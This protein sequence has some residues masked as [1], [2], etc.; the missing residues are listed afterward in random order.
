MVQ[1]VHE[2]TKLL[3]KTKWIRH[4]LPLLYI[5]AS[6]ETFSTGIFT[7]NAEVYSKYNDTYRPK[8]L[9]KSGVDGDVTKIVLAFMGKQA[10]LCL[11]PMSL[12]TLKNVEKFEWN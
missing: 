5:L 2:E 3:I 1:C 10:S 7:C 4:L 12:M 9:N 6:A 8:I 11:Y